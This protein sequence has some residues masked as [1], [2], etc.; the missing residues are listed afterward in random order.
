MI[1]VKNRV[2]KVNNYEGRKGKKKYFGQE[3]VLDIVW[4]INIGECL[5]ENLS[6]KIRTSWMCKS[7]IPI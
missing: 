6:E 1:K 2:I 7:Y 3:S 4:I 5:G